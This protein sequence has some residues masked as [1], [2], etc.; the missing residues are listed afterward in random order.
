MEKK[1][2]WKN[3]ITRRSFVK[4]VT[5]ATVTGLFVPSIL[6]GCQVQD[7]LQTILANADTMDEALEMMKQLAPLTN[8]GPMAAEALVSL[9][10]PESVIPFVERYKKRFDNP[11]PTAFQSITDK[12]WKE[13]V[14]DSRRNADWVV[15]FNNQLKEAEWTQ[16]VEKWSAILAPGLCAAAGHGLIRT[17]H[18][19][20]SLSRQK[21][22]LRL[23]ELAEGFGYWAAYYQLLPETNNSKIAK[24]K[25][26]QAVEKVPLLPTEKRLRGSIMN[27]LKGLNDFPEFG[28]SINLVDATGKPEQVLS[29][30]TETFATIYL[31]NVSDRNNLILLHAVTAS[32]CLRSLLPHLSP[33]TANKVLAY[34]WQTAAGLYSIGGIATPNKIAENKEIK[35]E[36]LIERAINL[37][38]EH[39]IKFTEACLREYALNPK[40][41]YLQAAQEGLE[42]LPSY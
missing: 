27:Q 8:H 10:R 41:I 26:R 30:L 14:G 2:L 20:R 19:V 39:A 42:R 25:P 33:A 37:N 23:H 16:V 32:T 6:S 3:K 40:P 24:L 38:E 9:N 31:K 15:F 36:D 12:N 13:A 17:C 4:T 21:N 35:K 18:A 11:Y 34:G 29:E 22:D 28:E 5:S 1:S 7:K